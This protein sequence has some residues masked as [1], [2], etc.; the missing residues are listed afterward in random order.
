MV[1]S[2]EQFP[3][4]LPS[5]T[6]LKKKKKWSVPPVTILASKKK[7]FFNRPFYPHLHFVRERRKKTYP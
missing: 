3:V 7:N 2:G 5:W 4:I 1:S 6:N